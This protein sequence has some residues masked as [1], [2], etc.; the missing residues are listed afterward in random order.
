MVSNLIIGATGSLIASFLFLQYTKRRDKAIDREKFAKST[1]KYIGYAP[2]NEGGSTI[3]KDRPLSNVEI[4]HLGG[5]LLQ[6]TLKEIN[7]P[8]EWQGLISMESN[9]YGTIIWRYKKLNNKE[10]D[11][12]E[13]RFGLKQFVFFPKEDK[14][15]AYLMGDIKAG[16]FNEFLIEVPG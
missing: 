15:V 8:H 10:V 1:G 16:Y 5:N 14:K 4:I 6:L 13:H 9:H 11:V 12:E 2:K 7:D 3:N